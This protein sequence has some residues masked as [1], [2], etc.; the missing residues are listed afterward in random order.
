MLE[1]LFAYAGINISIVGSYFV[2]C[3]DC[4]AVQVVHLRCGIN[5]TTTGVLSA[6]IQALITSLWML[7]HLFQC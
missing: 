7:H 5:R 2:C 4:Y 6:G 1:S 3:S